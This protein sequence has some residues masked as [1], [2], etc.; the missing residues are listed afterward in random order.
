VI[1]E[2][3]V[4]D[5]GSE[6][7]L[8]F[9]SVSGQP[10]TVRNKNI[11]RAFAAA[12]AVWSTKREKLPFSLELDPGIPFLRQTPLAVYYVRLPENGAL[13]KAN[14]VFAKWPSFL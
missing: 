4:S 8:Y 6:F 10:L 7:R 14:T 13:P 1:S 12:A 11:S 3:S 9:A 2:V 5:V